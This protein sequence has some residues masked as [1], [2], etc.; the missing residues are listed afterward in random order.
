M[1][2]FHTDEFIEWQKKTEPEL[3]KLREKDKYGL[4]D[5]NHFSL[6]KDDHNQPYITIKEGFIKKYEKLYKVLFLV[7]EPL[8]SYLIKLKEMYSITL[9]LPV[10]P[11]CFW[12]KAALMQGPTLEQIFN[13]GLYKQRKVNS[14]FL[15]TN[16]KTGGDICKIE[17]EFETKEDGYIIHMERLLTDFSTSRYI[18]CIINK[19]KQIIHLDASKF[20][21]EKDYEKRLKKPYSFD[22]EAR[23]EKVFC[24]D[25]ALPNKELI[26]IG[27]KYFEIHCEYLKMTKVK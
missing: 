12:T 25:G 16:D 18:H 4:I 14:T 3:K 5:V 26:K 8:L 22:K 9:K 19:K 11:F 13:K 27:K 7:D 6:D 23:K 21:Y 17:F 24:I 1:G 15:I 10:V 2:F 20:Y